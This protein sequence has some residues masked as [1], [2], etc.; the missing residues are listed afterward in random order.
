MWMD[1]MGVD[2][3]LLYVMRRPML[4]TRDVGFIR[5]LL[6][7]NN[8]NYSKSHGLF[9]GYD[10][11]I[12]FIG[13][14]LVTESGERWKAHRLAINPAFAATNLIK[15][16]PIFEK[17]ARQLR[18][19]FANEKGPIKGQYWPLLEMSGRLALDVIGD[20]GF[21]YPIGAILLPIGK[22]YFGVLFPITFSFHLG[23]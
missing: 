22:Y 8:N 18:D 17:Y 6:V 5:H 14:G 9:S 15:L 10:E 12:K 11:L 16:E 4:L 21:G 19:R 7:S 13:Y 1:Q 2:S 20:A 23:S 3:G